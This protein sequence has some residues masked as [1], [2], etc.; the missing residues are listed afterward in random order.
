[1]Y[2]LHTMQLRL[3]FLLSEKVIYANKKFVNRFTF[4][5][6]KNQRLSNFFKH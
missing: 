5:K 2:I 4:L 3:I 1:M 6:I